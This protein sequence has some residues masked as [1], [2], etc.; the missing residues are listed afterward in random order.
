MPVKVQVI[1][2]ALVC[3]TV[4]E[5]SAAQATAAGPARSPMLDSAQM[6]AMFAGAMRRMRPAQFVL[7]H[8]A[9]LA[10]TPE[11][12]PFLE[13]LVLAQADSE[14]VR[15]QRRAA[16]FLTE[17]KTSGSP[18]GA[19][20]MAWTGPIDE[21]AIRAMS[22]KQSDQS[23]DL[24]IQMA[25][26]RHA[27]GAVLTPAQIASLKRLEANDLTSGLRPPGVR[28]VGVIG[29]TR[30][31]QGDQSY[32]EFQVDKQAVLMPGGAVPTYPE[33]LR[34]TN[35]AGDVLAQFV[36]DS[37]GTP[38]IASFKVLKSTNELFAQ[39]VRDALPRMRFTPAER[40]GIKVRQ[41]VQMPFT[42]P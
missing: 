32:F 18:L 5:R 31:G 41:L 16:E 15:A 12:V 20:L 2:V 38:V 13:S 1:I 25:H 35:V 27:V 7:D 34:A 26:D 42:F 10:L 3:L 17:V 28:V 40:G 8:R 24:Q 30:P 14:R 33:S 4:A 22:R 29:G 9:E 23:A 21:D 39:A 6:S 11:Q 19:D 37:T 36:V